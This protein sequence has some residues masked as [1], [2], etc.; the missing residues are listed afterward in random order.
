MLD[1]NL[2]FFVITFLIFFPTNF[3]ASFKG[4]KWCYISVRTSSIIQYIFFSFLYLLA[5][6][7]KKFNLV[8]VFIKKNVSF[9]LLI[10]FISILL[11]ILILNN[12]S[13]TFIRKLYS[14]YSLYAYNLCT[15]AFESVGLCTC[16]KK[17]YYLFY[18]FIISY[19]VYFLFFS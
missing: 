9:T 2:L 19:Y 15:C 10:F 13:P 16:N 3:L 17:I 5:L 6:T 12:Y 7:A 4:W 8:D 11:D 1:S 14:V 18:K